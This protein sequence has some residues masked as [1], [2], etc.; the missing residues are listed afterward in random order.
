MVFNH[1]QFR[2]LVLKFLDDLSEQNAVGCDGYMPLN[3]ADVWKSEPAE[4]Y[5]RLAW[6]YTRSDW[7]ASP[8]VLKHASIVI[9]FR[10]HFKSGFTISLSKY[11]P[12][13]SPNYFFYDQATLLFQQQTP[14]SQFLRSCRIYNGIQLPC[15]EYT[16]GNAA[17]ITRGC[18]R[19]LRRMR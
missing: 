11:Y 6:S 16:V 18:L 13:R 2:P 14:L 3:W 8:D 15:V 5:K 9:T 17:V 4:C 12:F 10:I 19:R 7:E 1:G